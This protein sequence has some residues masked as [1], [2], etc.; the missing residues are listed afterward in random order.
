MQ[1]IM[2]GFCLLGCYGIITEMDGPHYLREDPRDYVLVVSNPSSIR[3]NA[4]TTLRY[5]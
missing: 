1:T 4:K 3:L 5:I 2:Y